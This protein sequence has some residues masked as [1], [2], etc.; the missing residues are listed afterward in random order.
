MARALERDMRATA[1]MRVGKAPM[2]GY[3]LLRKGVRGW[4]G[5]MELYRLAGFRGLSGLYWLTGLNGL[6]GA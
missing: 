6:L 2:E 3:R 4:N 5:V 1:Y